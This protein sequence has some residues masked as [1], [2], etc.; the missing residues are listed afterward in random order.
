M[1]LLAARDLTMLDDDKHYFPPYEAVPVVRADALGR[2]LKCAGL[3]GNWRGR[4][5]MSKCAR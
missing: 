4:L 3:A 1:D 5:M 2:F